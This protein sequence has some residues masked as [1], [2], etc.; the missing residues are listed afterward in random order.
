MHN[1]EDLFLIIKHM[2]AAELNLS[3][4]KV[5]P[6]SV[7]TNDLGADSLDIVALYLDLEEKF[8]ISIPEE[9]LKNIHTIQEIVSYVDK[10]ISAKK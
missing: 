3:A 9:K 4:E 6:E 8:E 1:T 7:L 5:F 2:V 10:N